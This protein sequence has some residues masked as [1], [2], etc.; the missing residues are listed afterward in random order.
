MDTLGKRALTAYFLIALLAVAF[1]VMGVRKSRAYDITISEGVVC[2]TQAQI[3]RYAK[4]RS[5]ANLNLINTDSP[6]ACGFVLV[7]YIKGGVVKKLNDA[8][9]NEILCFA[10]YN[11]NQWVTLTKPQLQ[12]ALFSIHEEG[13]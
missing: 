12:Y 1:I 3:E 6:H 10:Y 4:D 8:T 7:S 13:A 9:V 2:D 5:E 11:G